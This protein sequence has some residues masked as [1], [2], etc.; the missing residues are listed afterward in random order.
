M[1]NWLKILSNRVV[2]PIWKVDVSIAS[3]AS[4]SYHM[5]ACHHHKSYSYAS[6]L[7]AGISS[8]VWRW[9]WV[10]IENCSLGRWQITPIT[11]LRSSELSELLIFWS[12]LS[13][14][15]FR[16]RDSDSSYCS[17]VTEKGVFWCLAHVIHIVMVSWCLAHVILLAR[18]MVL[19]SCHVVS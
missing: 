13:T 16:K 7:T 8:S 12:I 5:V 6:K 2:C 9:T 18:V 10:L 19:S 1:P 3:S 15:L 4:F 17:S 11:K 14:L